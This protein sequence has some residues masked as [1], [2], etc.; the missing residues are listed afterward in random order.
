MQ[1][2][3]FWVEVCI[4]TPNINVIL[5]WARWF[6]KSLSGSSKCYYGQDISQIL[7]ISISSLNP[8]LELTQNIAII[9]T[10]MHYNMAI[11]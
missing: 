8:N 7:K 11:F 6:L 10:P 1:N 4:K 3:A 2:F 9:G 5:V